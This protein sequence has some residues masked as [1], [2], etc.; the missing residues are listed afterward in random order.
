MS[1]LQ[2]LPTICLTLAQGTVQDINI[3]YQHFGKPIGHGPV[4]LVNHAL[5]GNS[6]I[7]GTNGW[8]NNLIGPNQVIDLNRYCVLAFNIPGNGFDAKQDNLILNYQDFILSDIAR[9]FWKALELLG[10]KEL[11]ALIGGS[12]GGA[13]AWEMAFLEPKKIQN[14]IPI[15]THYKASNWLIGQAHVQETL[16]QQPLNPI[17]SARKHAMLLY[18]T[19]ESINQKFKNT[20]GHH[21]QEHPVEQWLNYHGQTLKDRFTLASYKLMNHLLKTIGRH[22]TEEDLEQMTKQIKANIYLIYSN[23]DYMFPA[24]QQIQS[25]KCINAYKENVYLL[26][27]NSIHGHDAFLMEYDQLN[28][29]L[30]PV[31]KKD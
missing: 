16:L 19:P 21:N 9:V 5:T 25:F 13:I 2:V 27:I 4:V 17:Q 31:F 8:W 24:T 12:L 29:L 10:I 15:A 7:A 11:Y 20:P 18:R 14:L 28:T 1:T 23:S 3:T 26:E 22:R 6:Q 30:Q